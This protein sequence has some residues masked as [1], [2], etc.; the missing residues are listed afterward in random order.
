MKQ[1][2]KSERPVL[3]IHGEKDDFVP[4]EHVYKNYEA[5][6]KGYKELWIAPDSKHAM[7]YKDHPQE[8]TQHVRD[9]LAKVKKDNL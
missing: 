5:K 8:Y 9:F 2:E 6:T 1:L 4:T 3:F 7:S